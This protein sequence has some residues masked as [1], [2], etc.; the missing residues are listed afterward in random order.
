M[1]AWVTWI[2]KCLSII[3]DDGSKNTHSF[4][5]RKIISLTVITEIVEIIV[6]DWSRKYRF[7]QEERSE[8]DLRLIPGIVE[9]I[10]DLWIWERQIYSRRDKWISLTFDR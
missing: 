9:I 4:E 5:E 6:D 8:L 3:D 10:V 2:D 1:E 7:M